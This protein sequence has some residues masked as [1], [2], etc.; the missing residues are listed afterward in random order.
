LEFESE[1][2]EIEVG[3]KE[4]DSQD[5]CGFKERK[6]SERPPRDRSSEIAIDGGVELKSPTC[7]SRD[8]IISNE[9]VED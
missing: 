8:D 4:T 7:K 2:I 3:G 1:T 6:E 5:S 9:R